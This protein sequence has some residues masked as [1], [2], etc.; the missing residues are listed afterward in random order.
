[1]FRY[2][3]KWQFFPRIIHNHPLIFKFK[4]LLCIVKSLR[5]I[6]IHLKILIFQAKTAK[7]S[8][9]YPQIIHFLYK[10]SLWGRQISETEIELT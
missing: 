2:P 8:L 9:G 6:T 5:L 4:P 10:T 3:Q 7:T 1:M